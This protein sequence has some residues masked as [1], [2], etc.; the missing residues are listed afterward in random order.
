MKIASTRNIDGTT[1]IRADMDL[2][3]TSLIAST[4]IGAHLVDNPDIAVDFEE[5]KNAYASL[6]RLSPLY[7]VMHVF[8]D[9]RWESIGD[10]MYIT[11]GVTETSPSKAWEDNAAEVAR[12][13]AYLNGK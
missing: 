13:A 12:I 7:G 11:I 2:S 5:I 6:L 1:L 3:Q 10:Q 4:I 9:V 8:D